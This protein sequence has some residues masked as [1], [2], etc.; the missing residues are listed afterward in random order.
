M[1]TWCMA[2]A[3]RLACGTKYLLRSHDLTRSYKA[4]VVL[5]PIKHALDKLVSTV[6]STVGILLESIAFS[7]F[8][9]IILYLYLYSDESC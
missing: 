5:V 1:H 9:S 2:R 8:Y 3:L 6:S 7:Y 4:K